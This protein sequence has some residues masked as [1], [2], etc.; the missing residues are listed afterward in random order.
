MADKTYI[1]TGR[2]AWHGLDPGEPRSRDLPDRLTAEFGDK[3]QPS[4]KG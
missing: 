3:R 4:P 1:R 2:S